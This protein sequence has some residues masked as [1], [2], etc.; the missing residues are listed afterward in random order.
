[1]APARR[2][3]DQGADSTSDYPA[4]RINEVAVHTRMMVWV[5]LEHGKVAAGG[6]AR[7][8]AG[9][10]RTV[11]GYLLPDGRVEA[12]ARKRHENGN[13]ACVHPIVDFSIDDGWLLLADQLAGRCDLGLLLLLKPKKVRPGR[14]QTKE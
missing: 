13:I 14:R 8:F 11:D 4:A 10:D 5:F 3:V 2:S 1:M 12:L 7:G 6:S 9:G